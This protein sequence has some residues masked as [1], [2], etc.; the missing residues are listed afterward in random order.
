MSESQSSQP[1]ATGMAGLP[2]RVRRLEAQL[3][4]LTEAVEVLVRGLESTPVAEPPNG[5]IEEAARRSHELL[6]L[7]KSAAGGGQPGETG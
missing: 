2:E 7:V 4:A 6:L 1:A 3:A 5:H